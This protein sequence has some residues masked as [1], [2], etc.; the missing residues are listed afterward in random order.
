MFATERERKH[1]SFPI[2]RLR[3]VPAESSDKRPQS[4]KA[5]TAGISVLQLFRSA[6]TPRHPEQM[7]SVSRTEGLTQ[8]A[9]EPLDDIR[10]AEGLRVQSLY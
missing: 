8:N 6:E 7:A 10:P 5:V 2:I 4:M 3:Q 9:V 1:P